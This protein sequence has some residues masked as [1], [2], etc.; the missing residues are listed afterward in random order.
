[1]ERRVVITGLGL[2]TPLGKDVKT[3]WQNLLKGKSGISR[4]SRFD[5]SPLSV[6]IAGEIKE[7][8][9]TER[10]DPK[11]TKRTER[12]SQYALWAAIE[13]VEDARLNF[14]SLNKNN[15][16]AVIGSGMGG[17]GTWEIEHEKFLS[18]GPSRV[19]PLLI[20]IMIPDMASG[21]VSILYG[22]RGPNF[23]T[24]S[25]CA[26]GAHAVGESF[27]FIKRGD[28][29]VMITGGSEAPITAFCVAAF[30]NMRALSKRNDEPEKASRP[31][32][33]DR[34][35]FVVSEGAGIVIIEELEHAL[36][37]RAKIYGEL[38]GYGTS[39]DGY[40]MTAP[41]PNGE[42][43]YISMGKAVKEAGIS[44]E[45]IDYINAHGTSTDLN[46]VTETQAIK[47]L[48]GARAKRIP[49]SSTKSM[50]GHSLGASGA[51]EFVVTALSVYHQRV[52]PTINLENP[53]PECDLDYVPEG[54]RELKIR[55]ALSNSLGF[56]GHNSTLIVGRYE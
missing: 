29:D 48:F 4:I 46:D 12:F 56:G 44:K 18:K 23:A 32:D 28:A 42:G 25:A 13:A 31:F 2:I 35:G 47:R 27:R 40:H 8:D 50:L 41:A 34:D 33:R 1:M 49:I 16:G 11:L 55:Y 24:V 26:S 30:S 51:I 14:E 38:C 20:P 19:S 37:R 45:E 7:F 52:H 39:G 3:T 9:P 22:I 21:Q 53:D 17:L 5:P 43:A 15:I 54:E 10:L 6:Q 36:K